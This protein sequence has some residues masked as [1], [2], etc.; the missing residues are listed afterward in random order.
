MHFYASG[1]KTGQVF[2]VG[3]GSGMR[4]FGSGTRSPY[5]RNVVNKYGYKAHVIMRFDNED[6]AFSLERALIR[7]YGRQNLCNLTDGGEGVSGV[8]RSKQFSEKVRKRMKDNNPF[9]D[10]K[11][12]TF[13]HEYHGSFTG[14]KKE[15]YEKF[16]LQRMNVYSMILGKKV[17]V[18]GWWLGLSGKP[19]RKNAQPCK[20]NQTYTFRNDNGVVVCGTI[21][22]ISKKIGSNRSDLY[23]VK[24]GKSK[25]VKGFYIVK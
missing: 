9:T 10:H 13:S 7:F 4:A 2:Y 19:K 16:N 12:Y 21:P 22:E 3:K 17:T 15:F 24:N 6:C 8:K 18:S 11:K 25:T 5:W 20:Y 14:T 23:K 1:P